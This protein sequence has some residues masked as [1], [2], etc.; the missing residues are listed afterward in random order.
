MDEVAAEAPVSALRRNW[1]VGAVAATAAVAGGGLAWWRHGAQAVDDAAVARLWGLG[2]DTPQ[3]GSLAFAAFKGK[4]LLVNFWATWCP[5]CVEEMPLLDRFYR[6]QAAN[7]WQVVGLAVDQPAA[8][9]K[10]LQ[11][12]PVSFAI[13][14]AGLEGVDLT[15]ALG[16]QAG[17]L[18]FTVVLGADGR[19]RQRRIGRV[20]E[21]D[22]HDWSSLT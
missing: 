16:N 8:V 5:P 18:P 13:G 6:Q 3:G 11:Q 14:L 20:S 9:R 7:G 21:A 12:T 19:M 2:F 10:F 4:P 15:K 1:L 22:L 17:G